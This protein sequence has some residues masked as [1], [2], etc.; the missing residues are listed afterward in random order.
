MKFQHLILTRFNVRV[1]DSIRPGPNWHKHRFELFEQFCYPSVKGQSQQNFE[2]LVFFDAETPA[3]Y[4]P[5]IADFARWPHFHPHFL[6]GYDLRDIQKIVRSYL[7]PDTTHLISTTLDNDDA[8]HRDFVAQVQ[9]Q[10]SGQAFELVNFSNGLRLDV[11]SEKVYACAIATNPFITLIEEIKSAENLLTITGCLP[12]ST[13]PHRFQAIR[14]VE[15][16]PLWLQVVHGRNVDPTGTWGRLREPMTRLEE[17]EV[18]F[19][20]KSPTES[21]IAITLDRLRGRGER[22]AINLLSPK[23]KEKIRNWLQKRR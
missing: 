9:A 21:K 19:R 4:R 16:Q 2:W 10:F 11:A 1:W 18:G 8:L 3:E 12:H 17:F 23:S 20:P 22:L 5:K 13:I 7:T 15:T 14:D 6:N